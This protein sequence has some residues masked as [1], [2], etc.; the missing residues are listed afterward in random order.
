MKINSAILVL[1]LSLASSVEGVQRYYSQN[2]RA[3]YS[4]ISFAEAAADAKQRAGSD[5]FAW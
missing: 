4:P 2:H 5:S 3:T 1:F